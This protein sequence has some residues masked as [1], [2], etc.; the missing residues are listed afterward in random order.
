MVELESEIQLPLYQLATQGIENFVSSLGGFMPF[1]LATLTDGQ[2][3]ILETFG[4]FPDV[5]SAQ[6][7]LV[8]NLIALRDQEQIVGCLVCVP[9]VV[10]GSGLQAAAIM[11]IEAEGC[12]PVR[13]TRQILHASGVPTLAQ[14]VTTML[15][16]AHVF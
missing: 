2:I 13:V 11:E 3:Q 15:G 14:E 7:G 6:D 1:A 16:D 8:G 10:P 5:E 9:V 4:E 12:K